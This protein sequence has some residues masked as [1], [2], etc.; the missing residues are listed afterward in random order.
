MCMMSICCGRLSFACSRRNI[1]T[2][3]WHVVSRP[4]QSHIRHLVVVN[5]RQ[6]QPEPVHDP[7][8]VVSDRRTSGVARRQQLRIVAATSQQIETDTT[9]ERLFRVAAA[10]FSGERRDEPAL[11]SNWWRRRRPAA[12]H[13]GAGPTS[14]TSPAAAAAPSAV[15]LSAAQSTGGAQSQTRD[16]PLVDRGRTGDGGTERRGR[17]DSATCDGTSSAVDDGGGGCALKTQ[18]KWQMSW[19]ARAD[20]CQPH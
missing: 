10:E 1:S 8:A 13:V 17:L 6:F 12:Q 18:R 14:R 16:G 15:G 9:S 11:H 7:A 3:S 20:V 2:R 5:G 19:T 4:P